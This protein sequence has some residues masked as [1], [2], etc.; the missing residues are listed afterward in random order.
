M[1]QESSDLQIVNAGSKH[2]VVHD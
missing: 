1:Q 2:H